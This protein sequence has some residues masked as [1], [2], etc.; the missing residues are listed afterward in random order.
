MSEHVVVDCEI[1][2]TIDQVGGWDHT[3]KMG[4]SVAAVWSYRDRRMKVYGEADLP[5]LRE[6][7]LAADRITAY[8]GF[9]FDMP[10]IWGLSKPDWLKSDQPSSEWF[11][12]KTQIRART[13]DLL[14]R[15]WKAAG[16]DPDNF[17]GKTHGNFKL[18]TVAAATMGVGKIGNG[19][20]APVWWQ[21]GLGHKV[22]DYC[23]DDVA[24]ERDLCD[25]IDRYGYVSNG[26][27]VVKVTKWAGFV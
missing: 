13:D 9:G 12:L 26:V 20:D 8:N 5:A 7:L 10:L 24:L 4:V 15:I 1:I 16:I 19:A 6:R 27:Q 3:D 2:R 23:L 21:A 25:F 22:I 18:D 11:G 17:R 14:R